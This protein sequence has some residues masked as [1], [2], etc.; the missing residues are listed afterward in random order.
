MKINII[1]WS[2][3]KW[4][5]YTFRVIKPHLSICSTS[6]YKHTKTWA[7]ISPYFKIPIQK[8]VAFS[9]TANFY[10]VE[11]RFKSVFFHL[12]ASS[13]CYKHQSINVSGIFYIS[14]W[15]TSNWLSFRALSFMSCSDLYFHNFG[16]TKLAW[17]VLNIRVLIILLPYLA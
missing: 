16:H 2:V 9:T 17:N 3:S 15:N 13:H 14:V 8:L 1:E 11:F 10:R 12:I 5:M 6:L 4:R 7:K